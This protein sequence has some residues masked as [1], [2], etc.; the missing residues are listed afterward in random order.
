VTANQA[1]LIGGTIMKQIFSES[2]TLKRGAAA[3]VLAMIW[4]LP[5]KADVPFTINMN[6][7]A[8]GTGQYGNLIGEFRGAMNTIESLLHSWN[9]P[10]AIEA[11]YTGFTLDVVFDDLG[12]PG[13]VL[14]QAGPTDILR[15]GGPGYAKHGTR[16]AVARAG[17]ATFDTNDMDFMVGAGLLR[18]VIIHEVF[19][20]L[21]FAPL[22]NDF[23][24]R[25]QTGFGYIGPNALAAYREASGQPFAPF[26]PL[27]T[28]GGGGT[29]GGHW[30]MDDPVF[31]DPR[32][33]YADIM[34][35]F[36]DPNMTISNI[37]L[38]QFRD[39]G[40]AVPSLDG[41]RVDDIWP[42]GPVTPRPP[43]PDGDDDDDDGV[44]DGPWGPGGD[45][46]DD[47]SGTPSRPRKPVWPGYGDDGWVDWGG[48]GNGNSGLDGGFNGGSG[49][50]GFSSAI[51]EPSSAWILLGVA[52]G[53]FARARR[54]R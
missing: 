41:G 13:G 28:M 9:G 39:L 1:F 46:D 21:G 45:G 36:V 22:W 29:A 12:G 38:A 31:F 6:F 23:G 17:T 44:T 53:F 24:Y 35:G 14:A 54:R 4:A 15:W 37:T 7:D 26:V 20:A 32:R 10:R 50:V 25:D 49:G 47:G 3:L 8:T 42:S 40:Y 2:W 43:A 30:A 52:G 48:Y 34:I 16:G 18:T 27:E 5:A 19:H 33:G 51:P 11:Q